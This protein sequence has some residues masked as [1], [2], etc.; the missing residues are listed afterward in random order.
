MSTR[1]ER[2]NIQI[3]KEIGHAVRVHSVSIN[4]N[5]KDVVSEYI[6]EGLRRDGVKIDKEKAA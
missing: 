1:N 3:K 2:L 6:V 4:R 5:L